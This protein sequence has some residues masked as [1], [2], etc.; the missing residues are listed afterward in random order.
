MLAVKLEPEMVKL[1]S[2]PAEPLHEIN[3]LIE[4]EVVMEGVSSSCVVKL[5][6]NWVVLYRLQLLLVSFSFRAI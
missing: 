1:C 4:P 5:P 3:E 6:V 2:V